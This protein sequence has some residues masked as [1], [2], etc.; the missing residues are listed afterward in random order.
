MITS[1]QSHRRALAHYDELARIGKALAS[2]VRLRLLD[3]LR[4]GS[5]NVEELAEA[6]DETVANSSRHLQQ[7]RSARLVQRS[8]R[9]STSATGWP[10]RASRAPSGCCAAWPRPCSPRWTGC[11][12]SWARWRPAEREALLGRPAQRRGAPSLDVRPAEE[13]E[14]GHLP[15]ARSIPLRRAARPRLDEVPR[16]RPVVAYCRGPYCPLAVGAAEISESGG[17]PGPPPRPRR[18]GPR[19]GTAAPQPHRP[20]PPARGSPDESPPRRRRAVPASPWPPR[21]APPTSSSATRRPRRW[22]ASPTSASSG[23][24]PRR[25]SPRGTSPARWT[26]TPTTCT[27]WTT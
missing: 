10:T 5:R 17:L 11:G 15:G 18:P 8:A 2:P 24:T 25:S 27:T 26:P 7:M 16:D 12:A 3:L 20:P 1:G 6:A 23:P 22:S 21:P 19:P 14:A 13:F 4:Q 9:A